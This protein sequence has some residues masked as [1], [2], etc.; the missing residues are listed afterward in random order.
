MNH[1]RFCFRMSVVVGCVVLV[2]G[3]HPARATSGAWEGD[4]SL[5]WT[6][7]NN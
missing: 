3:V 1:T 6:N 7:N 4:T 2:F 5:Y